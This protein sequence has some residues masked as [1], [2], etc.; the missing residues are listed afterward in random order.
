[1]GKAVHT[2]NVPDSSHLLRGQISS[3]SLLLYGWSLIWGFSSYNPVEAFWQVFP[4]QKENR[5]LWLG[6]LVYLGS[7]T[8][9]HCTSAALPHYLNPCGKL[10]SQESILTPRPNFTT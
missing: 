6:W 8:N 10:Q 3:H 5:S 2:E 4:V 1:M 7:L 9:Q